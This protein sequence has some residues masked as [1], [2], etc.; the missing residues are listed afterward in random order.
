MNSGS[1]DSQ[2]ETAF[3]MSDFVKRKPKVSARPILSL[4]VFGKEESKCPAVLDVGQVKLT[5]NARTALAHALRHANIGHG[6]S[7]MLPAYH[8]P[9]MVTPIAWVGAEPI[10]YPIRSDTSV[11]IDVLPKYIRSDTRAIIA[12]HYF[13]FIQDMRS[14]RKFCDERKL[15]LIED[16][17][18]AFFGSV[19][20][21]VIGSSGDYAI[22]SI[23]KFLPIYEGGCLVSARR[24]L[25]DIK[26]SYGGLFLQLKSALNTLEI[27]CEYGR[28]PLV[29]IFLRVKSWIWNRLKSKHD[30]GKSPK[31][32]D[33]FEN[34]TGDDYKFDPNLIGL[35]MSWSSIAVMKSMSFSYA[36]ERRR[37]N[38][39]VLL[40]A[41]SNIKGAQPLFDNLPDNVYPQVFPMLM[42]FPDK[43]FK[44]LKCLGIP[45]IRFG[46]YRWKGVD[47]ST[48][49]VSDELSRRVFQIPC[50]QSLTPEELRWM[51]DSII[52]VLNGIR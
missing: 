14:L 22:A 7:V 52:S 42:D 50:H 38:Y 46:E 35:S 40:N 11:D 19:N 43:V 2:N 44:P 51:I 9:A 18:H 34:T 45:I 6:A 26:I 24:S 8:C 49:P 28:L 3:C 47:A 4:D 25:E 29:N 13:G 33:L 37:A 5:H 23:M 32:L 41:L 20:G 15:I 30:E 21:Q 16:C 48:C 10:F 27:A 36:C 1:F 31:Q 12:V 17:A 39:K